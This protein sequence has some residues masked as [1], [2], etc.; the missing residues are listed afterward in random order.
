MN[1]EQLWQALRNADAAGDTAAA[2]RFAEMIRRLRA[3]GGAPASTR[4]P[5]A[6]P[7]TP[8]GPALSRGMAG[9][10]AAGH[11]G[12]APM[13]APAPMP[14]ESTAVRPQTVSG[15]GGSWTPNM[16]AALA[17]GHGGVRDVQLTPAEEARL[18]VAAMDPL[19]RRHNARYRHAGHS[20]RPH[21]RDCAP[22]RGCSCISRG[23]TRVCPCSARRAQV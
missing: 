20:A 18:D 9:A 8:A 17:T 3:E 5:T 14:Q 2:K 11:G 16:H 13:R 7:T 21:H 4:V 12:V 19:A 15:A 6:A 23:S 10:L 1:E 22:W